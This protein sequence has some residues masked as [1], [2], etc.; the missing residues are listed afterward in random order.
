MTTIDDMQRQLE[1]HGRMLR[2]AVALQR[3][4]AT[5]EE[6][7]ESMRREREHQTAEARAVALYDALR[8]ARDAIFGLMHDA[9]A[10]RQGSCVTPELASAHRQAQV[11][12]VRF[13]EWRRAV[14]K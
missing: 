12:L 2:D 11:L 14:R 9:P 10:G 8:D 4:V 6:E 1:M 13:E 7:L 3:R 5:L